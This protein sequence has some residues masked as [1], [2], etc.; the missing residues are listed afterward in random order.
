VKRKILSLEGRLPGL[1]SPELDDDSEKRAHPSEIAASI[2][3]D[4]QLLVD[5]LSLQIQLLNSPSGE[6]LPALWKA[7]A[8]AERGLRLSE[9]L[10]RRIADDE[11]SQDQ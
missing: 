1:S 4:L 5:T 9:L 7:R 6:M 8:T 3:K 11:G 10:I 2:Q